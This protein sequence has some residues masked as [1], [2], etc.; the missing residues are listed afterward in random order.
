V[1]RGR[2]RVGYTRRRGWAG[3]ASQVRA[4]SL[5]N[6][7]TFWVCHPAVTRVLEELL[8]GGRMQE[9]DLLTV[10][11]PDRTLSAFKHIHDKGTPGKSRG[12]KATGP[13]LLRVAT[14]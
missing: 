14:P 1:S 8:G 7:S 4:G 12:R 9:H 13:R 5:S 10:P 11:V 6:S 3:K 2:T